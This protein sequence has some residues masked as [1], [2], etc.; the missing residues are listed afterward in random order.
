MNRLLLIGVLLL[1]PLSL[2]AEDKA[3]GFSEIDKEIEAQLAGDE[4]HPASKA[5]IRTQWAE[6]KQAHQKPGQRGE[7]QGAR[8]YGGIVCGSEIKDVRQ[9]AGAYRFKPSSEDEPPPKPFLQIVVSPE[10]SRGTTTLP[11]TKLPPVN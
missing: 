8:C 1:C 3:D 5:F 4:W 7:F 9:F 10:G 6:Y 2:S 11:A